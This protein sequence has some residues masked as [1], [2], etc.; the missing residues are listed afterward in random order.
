MADRSPACLV[1]RARLFKKNTQLTVQNPDLIIIY[2]A[3]FAWLV[4]RINH[5]NGIV[6]AQQAVKPGSGGNLIIKKPCNSNVCPALP[7][8]TCNVKCFIA[9]Q[10]I[11]E[12]F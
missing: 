7:V 10:T 2:T 4:N 8:N 9:K 5:G 12:G 6:I 1:G 3:K 11:E